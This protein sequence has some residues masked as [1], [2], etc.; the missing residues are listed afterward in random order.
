M[1]QR[2]TVPEMLAQLTSAY[3]TLIA[4]QTPP[5]PEQQRLLGV[6]DDFY[7]YSSRIEEKLWEHAPR[8]GRW[9]FAENLWHITEQAVA[10]A[11]AADPEPVLYFIDHGK[12]HVGQA[13]EILAIFAFDKSSAQ[14]S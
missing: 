14:T 2:P 8:P 9:S 3:N 1:P 11:G 4:S 12:E 5:Q 6:L 7:W 10:E 13:A